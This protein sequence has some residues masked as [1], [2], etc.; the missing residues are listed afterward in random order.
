MRKRT[1][2]MMSRTRGGL[3]LSKYIQNLFR[4]KSSGAS[5]G[6]GG[7]SKVKSTEGSM[8]SNDSEQAVIDFQKKLQNLPQRRAISIQDKEL[9]RSHTVEESPRTM[10][11]SIDSERSSNRSNSKDKGT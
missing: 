9:H 6:S 11:R 8:H 2:T 5:L 3:R 1:E 4:N 7:G 10:R